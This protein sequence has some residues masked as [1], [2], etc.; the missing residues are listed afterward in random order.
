M[1]KRLDFPVDEHGNIVAQKAIVGSDRG[2][3]LN[4]GQSPFANRHYNW[5]AERRVLI[6]VR[7]GIRVVGGQALPL[8]KGRL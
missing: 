5:V 1:T 6:R 7:T 4:P 8:D 2:R 3:T